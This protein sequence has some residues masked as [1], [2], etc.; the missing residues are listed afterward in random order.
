MQRNS[1][2]GFSIT[3]LLV[4][5]ATVAIL[6]AILLPVLAKVRAE[7]NGARCTSNL[8]QCSTAVSMYAQDYGGWVTGYN[9]GA[10]ANSTWAMCLYSGGYL[11]NMD[12]A[13]CPSCP[14]YSWDANNPKRTQCTY[15]WHKEDPS[16]Y[17][18]YIA[19]NPPKV[20]N[21]FVNLRKIAKPEQFITI[22]DSM[23]AISG[24]DTYKKQSYVFN[25]DNSAG[26]LIHLR[27]SGLANLVFADGHVAACDKAKIKAAAL[28]EMGSWRPVKV[29]EENG[30]VV[31]INP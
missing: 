2:Q 6:S 19:A 13:V 11:K 20:Y 18:S 31:Q 16:V 10:G 12:A 29:A 4:V 15:G 9:A 17:P 3:E 22:A 1:K 5:M 26:G 30:S 8:K 25:F 24:W 28:A 27:H 23:G 14:P 7:E 21:C